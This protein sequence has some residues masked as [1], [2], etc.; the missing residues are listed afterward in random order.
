[1]SKLIRLQQSNAHEDENKCLS[2]FF[3]IISLVINWYI[4]W[5]DRL[6]LFDLLYFDWSNLLLSLIRGRL[7]ILFLLIRT[8]LYFKGLI[9]FKNKWIHTKP[10]SILIIRSILYINNQAKFKQ[11]GNWKI[12][13]VNYICYYSSM[14]WN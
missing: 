14:W 9:S 8:D 5:K 1:M 12:R 10:H 13:K 4:R 7:L 11:R 3:L 6:Y 2:I